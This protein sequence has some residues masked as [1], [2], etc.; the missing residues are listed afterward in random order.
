MESEKAGEAEP[1]RLG[2][3]VKGEGTPAGREGVSELEMVRGDGVVRVL[4]C[5]VGVFEAAEGLD[6]NEEADASGGCSGGCDIY[7]AVR[8]Q[9]ATAIA[10]VVAPE[11]AGP[12]RGR[13]RRFHATRQ[14]PHMTQWRAWRR[15]GGKQRTNERRRDTAE[16]TLR[17]GTA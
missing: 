12:A 1:T 4:C 16:E 10:T 15:R 7:T 9:W 3:K 2:V 5:G 17:S 11:D 14:A 6:A 13:Q 8:A